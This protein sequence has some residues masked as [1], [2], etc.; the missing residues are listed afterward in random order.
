MIG[1]MS[2]LS[3]YEILYYLYCN[4]RIRESL[5]LVDYSQISKHRLQKVTSVLLYF[6]Y[7]K[8]EL[9]NKKSIFL[10]ILAIGGADVFS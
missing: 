7:R 1:G 4:L 5:R 3:I 8:E 2:M 6:L 9:H 10:D